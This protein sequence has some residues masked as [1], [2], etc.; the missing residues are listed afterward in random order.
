VAVVSGNALDE[1]GIFGRSLGVDVGREDL[2]DP[3]VGV[4][5]EIPGH[6]RGEQRHIAE[7]LRLAADLAGIDQQRGAVGQNIERALA[8]SLLIM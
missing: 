4:R 8:A 6:D 3:C 2:L 7:I 5:G 1:P